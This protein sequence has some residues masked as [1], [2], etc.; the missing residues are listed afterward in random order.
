MTDEKTI[1]AEVAE[2][3]D[4]TPTNPEEA[5]AYIVKRDDGYHV[6]DLEGNEGPVCKIVDDGKTIA[7]TAN[8][9]NRQWYSIKKAEAAL[10]SDDLVPLYFKGTR[11]FDA[12]KPK[13][14]PNAKLIGY[15]P[16][17]LQAEYKAIVD[18]AREAME[19]D[20]KKPM[21]EREKLEAKIAKAKA[22]LEALIANT[23][24]E[25]N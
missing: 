25:D 8:K 16:E 5:Q 15:L 9:A 6:M 2:T 18:R 13:A 3:V 24:K 11:H 22:A 1:T 19:A 7:L 12:N 4:A 20:R 17:D 10:E 21:T 23:E 14:L